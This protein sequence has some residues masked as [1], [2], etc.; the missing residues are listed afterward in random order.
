M[1]KKKIILVF[2][3]FFIF[4]LMFGYPSLALSTDTNIYTNF[5]KS[6]Y[7]VDDDLNY[8]IICFEGG[9]LCSNNETCTIDIYYPNMT[10][11]VNNANMDYNNGIFNISIGKSKINIIGEYKA[12]VSCLNTHDISVISVS[13]DVSFDIVTNEKFNGDFMAWSIAISLGIMGIMFVFGFLSIFN[14]SIWMK[15]LFMFGSI[16][17]MI[18]GSD[19]LMKIAIAASQT[20]IGTVLLGFYQMIIIFAW[21]SLAIFILLLFI[22]VLDYFGRLPKIIKNIKERNNQLGKLEE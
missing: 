11:I 9:L 7:K 5:E 17:S 8:G 16:I 13:T 20:A 4:M 21:F 18:V 2:I 14:K 6:T 15:T 22:D 3:L 12:S 1:N 10:N 19:M